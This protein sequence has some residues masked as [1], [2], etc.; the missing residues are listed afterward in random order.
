[1]YWCLGR[2]QDFLSTDQGIRS[3]VVPEVG[4]LI[5]F[6]VFAQALVLAYNVEAISSP[7]DP[8]LVR[9]YLLD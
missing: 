2:A 1:M 9:L 5:Q 4:S 8:N 3:D 6:P 7:D